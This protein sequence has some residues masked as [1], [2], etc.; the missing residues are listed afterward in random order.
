MLYRLFLFLV[1]IFNPKS[2]RGEKVWVN[3]KL[4]G[5]G[6]SQYLKVG[7][8]VFDSKG[9]LCVVTRQGNI[10]ALKR[11]S[12]RSTER[13]VAGWSLRKA[14]EIH[15]RLLN[16]PRFVIMRALLH[17]TSWKFKWMMLRL[18][19]RVLVYRV[20]RRSPLFTY[21]MIRIAGFP[22]LWAAKLTIRS[23]FR[24]KKSTWKA[25]RE[26]TDRLAMLLVGGYI[27]LSMLF[28]I[29]LAAQT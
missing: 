8:E 23:I 29:T 28:T 22:P 9:R 10:G 24:I 27:L 3:P 17:G 6:V 15:S 14:K 2:W 21:H 18:S 20:Y 25:L 26:R 16:S 12:H 5:S 11:L 19:I 7:S 4:L 1:S 13:T